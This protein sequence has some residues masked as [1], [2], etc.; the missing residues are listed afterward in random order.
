MMKVHGQKDRQTPRA[1]PKPF[2]DIARHWSVGFFRRMSTECGLHGQE[3]RQQDSERILLDI[4]LRIAGAFVG[5]FT[6]V[7]DTVVW[8][9]HLYSMFVA[10]IGA[11]VLLVLYHMLSRRRALRGYCGGNSGSAQAVP[12]V[13]F[14]IA[15]RFIMDRSVWL[16]SIA[17]AIMSFG[18]AGYGQT[19]I[20][21]FDDVA[22]KWAGQANT[23]NVTLE[24]DHSGRFTARY[25]LGGESGEARLEAGALVIPLPK[26]RGT[27]QLGWDGDTLKGAGQTAGK[28]WVVTLAR[29]AAAAKSE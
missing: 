5:D 28:T 20:A 14:R 2:H 21:S 19:L 25:A 22:G 9:A 27:L 4:V 23:H 18:N 24:I 3:D 10:V 29:T 11:I 13:P 26:H 6:S 8:R 12:L 15:L 7:L 1:A 16:A 17:L